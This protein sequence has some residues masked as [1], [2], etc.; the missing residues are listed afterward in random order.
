MIATELIKYFNDKPVRKVFLFGSSVLNE[1]IA[2]DID[3]LLELDF[4]SKITLFDMGNWLFDLENIFHK[5]I[6]LITTENINEHIRPFIEKQKKL[7]F[8]NPYYA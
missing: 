7:I 2:N 1:E 3:I 4:N 6:D 8:T 5:K